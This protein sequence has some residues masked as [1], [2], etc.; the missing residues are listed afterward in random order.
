[1]QISKQTNLLKWWSKKDSPILIAGPCSAESEKQVLDT[2]HQIA[3]SGQATI[4]R[5]GVWKPRTRPGSFEG[6]GVPALSWL[7]KVKKETGLL[8]STEVA[9]TFHVEQALKHDVDVLWIGART[10]VNPFLVQE[11][12]ESLRGVDIPILIKNPIHAEIALWDGA[13]ERFSKVGIKNIGAIHRGFFSPNSAPFRN[14]PFWDLAIELMRLHPDMPII[15]DPSHMAGRSDLIEKLSQTSLDLNFDG[16]IIESHNNPSVA[17]SDA[18]QQVTPQHLEKIMDNLLLKPETSSNKEY[19]SHL[20]KLRGNLNKIDEDFL[21]I[22]TRRVNAVREIEDFKSKN[23]VSAFEIKRLNEILK[24]RILRGAE[25]GLSES[26]VED[27]YNTLIKNSF[28]LQTEITD[29]K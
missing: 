7:Q 17:L 3:N 29:K 12:A 20:S 14:T 26:L 13:I 5:A 10:T 9:T 6:I 11:I 16:F 24:T 1:M 28:Q 4:F 25:L 18:S 8:V 2:A 27:I 15:T 23:N 21:E 22:L 19:L